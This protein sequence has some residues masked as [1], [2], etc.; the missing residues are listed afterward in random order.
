[1]EVIW[2][3]SDG[4]SDPN[5][6]S[7][8]ANPLETTQYGLTVVDSLGCQLKQR[9]LVIVRIERPV[10]IPNVFSPDGDGNNDYFTIFVGPEVVAIKQ[11]LVFDRWGDMVHESIPLIPNDETHGWN[12]ISS[13]GEKIPSGV[14]AYVAEIEFNDGSVEMYYGSITLLR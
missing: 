10:F 13:S 14:Y 1:M 11:L 12:G 6:L 3:P 8:F 7:T 9:V 5:S 2:T 4:L